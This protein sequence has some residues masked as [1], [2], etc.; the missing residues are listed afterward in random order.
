MTNTDNDT[1][2]TP[3]E[4]FFLAINEVRTA[5]HFAMISSSSP[6]ATMKAAVIAY[7]ETR[8]AAALALAGAVPSTEAAP[9]VREALELANQISDLAE[10]V[11]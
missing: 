3:R 5:A 1:A 9:L 11:S 10:I 8:R 6:T 4:A 2:D 7:R